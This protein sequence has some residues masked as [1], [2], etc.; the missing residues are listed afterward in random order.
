[1]S[2]I[3]PEG[4]IVSVAVSDEWISTSTN[5][6]V[7]TIYSKMGELARFRSY[8]G[9]IL[10]SAISSLFK[11]HI[12]G[13]SDGILV[14]TSLDTIEQ[15][16]VIDLGNVTPISIT[17]TPTWGFILVYGECVEH[18]RQKYVL[19]VHTINGVRVRVKTL[20]DGPIQL[21]TTFSSP[22]GFDYVAYVIKTKVYVSEVFFL[23]ERSIPKITLA[24]RTHWIDY[25]P[26]LQKLILLESHGQKQQVLLFSFTPDDF[27]GLQDYMA[28][29]RNP[30]P[31]TRAFSS[32]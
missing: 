20:S 6:F 10:C 25:H 8:R 18:G 19:S 30:T 31:R 28:F 14:V 16:R 11:V 4:T 2:E 13:T 21:M 24:G 27:R 7:T 5:D 32:V 9:S 12:M 3:V 22:R 26:G 1:M 29:K 15:V 23:S 17:V